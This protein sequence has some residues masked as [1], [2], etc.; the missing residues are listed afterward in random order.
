MKQ[1][2]NN[3]KSTSE[4]SPEAKT[5]HA[6]LK[7]EWRITDG[8]G[9]LTLLTLCQSLDRLREAQGILATDGIITTDRWGQ[10]KAHPAS[11]IEREARAGLLACLKGLN[12]DLESLEEPE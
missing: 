6:R 9:S 4:L 8:A 7:K 11:T 3:R 2:M 12:L 10:K 1:A 5:L